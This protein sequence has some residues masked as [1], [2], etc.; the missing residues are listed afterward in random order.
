[1]LGNLKQVRSIVFDLDGTLYKS[2]G[3]AKEIQNVAASLVAETRGIPLREG[4][5]LLR[6]SRK[7]L[8]ELLEEE[9]T[10]TRTCLTLGI[11]VPE[12]HRAMQAGVRPE[13]YLGPD[14]VL[15]ALLDSLAGE[16]DLYLYTNN[17]LP[18]TEKILALLGV[19]TLFRRIYTIEF[20]WT[21]KPDP[22]TLQRILE[23]I[24]GPPHSF[25]FVG[26]REQVD[27][28]VPQALGIPTLLVS[29]TADLLQIH[30][31]LGIIP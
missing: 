24:G 8:A 18:L 20:N 21:P 22:E 7:R 5:T 16:W 1:M 11:E 28:K 26:D 10:L 14:L 23:D 15:Q 2:D 31:I 12:F 27:L 19:E 17:S 9:P 29:E 4:R 25:L 6:N 3:L 30:K 13:Q